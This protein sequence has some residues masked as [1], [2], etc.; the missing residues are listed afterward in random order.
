MKNCMF[1]L[2]VYLI[3]NLNLIANDAKITFIVNVPTFSKRDKLYITGNHPRLGNWHPGKIKM[4]YS[5]DNTWVKTVPIESNYA[6]EFKFTRGTWDN[7]PVDETGKPFTNFTH[8]VKR[9]TTLYFEF[10]F[11]KDKFERPIQGQITGD[12]RYHRKMKIFRLKPRDIVV[13]LPPGYNENPDR[14]YPVLYMHD[15]QNLFDPRTSAFGVDWQI[16]ET[17]DS[18]IRN[19]LIEPLIIVG[20]YNTPLR[21]P[22]YAPTKLG[23]RYRKFVIK[24]IKPFIDRNYRTLPDK[25]HTVVGGSSMGGLVSF[26]FA[27]EHPEIF[28]KAICMSPAFKIDHI[29]YVKVVD[30]YQGTRKSIIIYIDNG[31]INLEN[32]LQPGIDDM[33]NTLEKQ[34]FIENID[35]FWVKDNQAHHFERDWGKRMKGVLLLFYSP[36]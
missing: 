34:G 31:G 16:D 9:D 26:M 1:V 19:G 21:T 7:E 24:K 4:K 30:A 29:D 28:S 25:E 15:G 8:T 2:I 13:W 23:K 27:W 36:D 12:V 18:L 10:N 20:I 3:A 6:L 35:Y 32:E 11:W 5:S 22:E 17:A 14:R 33:L